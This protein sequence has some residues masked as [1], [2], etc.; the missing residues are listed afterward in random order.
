MSSS[1]F[2]LICS[3]MRITI[4]RISS[5]HSLNLTAEQAQNTSK[6]KVIMKIIVI[7]LIVYCVLLKTTVALHLPRISFNNIKN[8]N[9][10]S[11]LKHTTINAVTL[12][13][14]PEKTL[15]LDD[16][17]FVSALSEEKS[18]D[19]LALNKI[20]KAMPAEV[21]E[22]SLPKSLAYMAFD[23]SMWGSSLLLMK[24]LVQ[25]SLWVT[26]PLIAKIGA[27]LLYW[28]VAGFFMWLV[29]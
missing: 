10:A 2:A 29:V 6:F 12:D 15:Q 21:F 20:L 7:L 1:K 18:D 27:S 17:I 13:S 23:F 14:I 25:S 11:S 8:R 9:Q 28:N 22:K 26:L 5:G 24:A 3:A 19:P 16:N 4:N